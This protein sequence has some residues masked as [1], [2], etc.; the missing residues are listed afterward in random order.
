MEAS[1][2]Q[3]RTQLPQQQQKQQQSG[4]MTGALNGRRA[5]GICRERKVRC[6][7]EEPQCG[8]CARLGQDC[9]YNVRPR[10]SPDD[11]PLQISQ[12]NDRLAKAEALLVTPRNGSLPATT[13]PSHLPP[14]TK[15]QFPSSPG[16]SRTL[17][18]GSL[19]SASSNLASQV[20]MDV[21]LPP[22]EVA[23]MPASATS[24]QATGLDLFA[25]FTGS[26]DYSAA[27]LG[28]DWVTM[29]MPIPLLE[30]TA[31][32]TMTTCASHTTAF[33]IQDT[34][35]A[36]RHLTALHRNYF[37]IVYFSLPF[38]SE[39]RFAAELT[40]NSSAPSV[41]ALGYAVA[42]VGCTVSLQ[43]PHLLEAY[44]TAARNYAEQCEREVDEGGAANLNLLQALLFIIRFEI[45]DRRLTRAWMT[46][47]RA[48]RLSK[49][50]GLHR[51]D[52]DTNEYSAGP[53]LHLNLPA[54]QDPLLLEERRR[55]FW[56]L[57]VLESY[58]RTRTGVNCELGD[59]HVRF[60]LALTLRVRLPSP[61]LLSTGFS[62]IEMPFLGDLTPETCPEI[63]TYAACVLMV[64][65]AIKCFDHGRLVENDTPAFGFWDN[66]HNLVQTIDERIAMLHMHM[67]AKAVKEDPVAFSMYMNLR[68][69]E[70]L[71]HEAAI[72]QVERIG[73]PRLVAAE[74]QRRSTAAAF[75]IATTVRLNW[76]EEQPEHGI[77]RLQATFIGWPLV[78][79]MKAL[80]RQLKL[81]LSQQKH[82]FRHYH[83]SET[84]TDLCSSLRLLM[85]ALDH[86]E[87]ADGFWHRST[88]SIAAT[89]KNQH[90]GR[91]LD[92]LT[93]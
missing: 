60:P 73:H 8:R 65:I 91:D 18:L 27:G 32:P 84:L 55:S 76:P 92:S 12:I 88:E 26:I 78:M 52:S 16:H 35:I 14:Q 20:A 7:R 75:K 54:T 83:Q 81:N 6:D 67:N 85:T 49:L 22:P 5:C 87:Q 44:Y 30:S 24:D 17:N 45:T 86:I 25:N 48:V 56:F 82:D 9:S 62:P 13:P 58:M 77:F 74:S 42:L 41:L 79:A 33:S 28:P 63:S 64:D 21:D 3:K 23:N 2:L 66:H 40:G 47:G 46:L 36:S 50:L 93:L 38:L 31:S 34:E 89:L 71:F 72:V 53:D 68:A 80:H 51:I 19:T 37:E 1:M 70:I 61:G 11:L 39:S 15:P 43:H 90:D 4:R 57:Y 10:I 29:T 69:T 59:V